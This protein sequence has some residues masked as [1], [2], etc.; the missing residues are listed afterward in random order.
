V[1]LPF[2]ERIE[3]PANFD[4]RWWARPTTKHV[5]LNS[6]TT[7]PRCGGH[8]ETIDASDIQVRRRG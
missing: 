2:V 7:V 5:G 3:H 8:G 6:S 1:R 4:A